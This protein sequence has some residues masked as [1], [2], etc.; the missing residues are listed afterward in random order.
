MDLIALDSNLKKLDVVDLT[1]S[2]FDD[3]EEFIADLNREQLAKYGV[4]DDGDS[5]EPEYAED[6]IWSKQRKSGTASITGHVTLFNTGDLHE[7]IFSMIS[8]DELILGSHDEKVGQLTTKYGEFLGLTKENQ[9]KVR[10]EF[11]KRF[12][13][14]LIQGIYG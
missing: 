3:M 9:E 10:V 4:N 2:I 7:S 14:A 6:T 12:E 11:L 13:P 5:L 1:V 8:G